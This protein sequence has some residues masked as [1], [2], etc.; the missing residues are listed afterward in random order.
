MAIEEIKRRGFTSPDHLSVEEQAIA[1]VLTDP[2]KHIKEYIQDE[3]SFNGRYVCSDL[4]K[5]TFD[6]YRADKDSRNRYNN[7]VHN[8][9]SVLAAEQFRRTLADNSVPEMDT[10]I[11]ITGSP[12]AGK[13]STILSSSDLPAHIRVVFEGQLSNPQTTNEKVQQAIDAGL[14]VDIVVVHPTPENALDNTLSR[15]YREGRGA[16]INVMASIQGGLPDSLEMVLERFGETV[17]L[18][19]FD[20]RDKNKTI[21][22]SGWDNLP[23]LRSEGNYEQI[24]SRLKSTLDKYRDQ[25]VIDENAYRQANGEPPLSKD[26][27]VVRQPGGQLEQNANRRGLPRGNSQ[28]NFLVGSR[29]GAVEDDLV[30]TA[31]EVEREQQAL[32]ETT[33]PSTDQSYQEALSVYVQAKHDQVERI[34][35]QIE[36][37]IDRQQSRLQQSQANQPGIFSMPGAKRAWQTQ[38]S[39]QQARLQTLHTR[40]ETV[41]EIAN[42]MGVHAPRVEELAARKLRAQEPGLAAEWDETQVARRQHDAMMRMK[43]KQAKQLSQSGGLSLSLSKP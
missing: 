20:R 15:Y 34:E 19:V 30:D 37:L 8:A 22:L 16:G 6:T 4:F 35:D 40:L 5:E 26:T 36:N 43:E 17:S 11:F 28:E 41:R 10:A 21:E 2:E 23:L 39:K 18:T 14:K 25:G 29:S 38:Q 9:A 33:T 42:D 32:L 27:R 12:G 13:T 7:A 31:Q 1:S 3:R 24:K